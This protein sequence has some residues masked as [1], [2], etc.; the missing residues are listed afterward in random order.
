MQR[1]RTDAGKCGDPVKGK[2]IF[3]GNEIASF[4]LYLIKGGIF[5]WSIA[6][7]MTVDLTDDCW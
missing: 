6:T 2:K 4:W 3:V 5:S 1:A 7:E